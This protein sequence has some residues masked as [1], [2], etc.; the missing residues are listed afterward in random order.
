M[1]VELMTKIDDDN[2]LI[3]CYFIIDS[4]IINWK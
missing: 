2:L 1:V 3:Y 4:L